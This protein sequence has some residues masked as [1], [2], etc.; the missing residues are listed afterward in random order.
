MVSL[1]ENKELWNN[2]YD[3][4]FSGEEWSTLWG[5]SDMQWYGTILPRIQQFVPSPTVLE[6]A[7]GFGR[8][9]KYLIGLA[10]R[11]IV[12]DLAEKCIDHCKEIFTNEKHI[13]YYV[14]D[15]KSL[16]M[17]EDNTLD[18]V[19]S[20]D[21]LV[22]AEMVVMHIY[23]EQL[24]KKLS[25][26]GVAFIHHS[27]IGEYKKLTGDIVKM[28][29]DHGRAF[30]VTADSVRASVESA[31]LACISQETLNWG[32]E[33]MTDCI[34]VFTS[35]GSVYER[36][37]RTIANNRFMLE[38][39]QFNEIASIYGAGSFHTSAIKI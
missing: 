25:D 28:G 14:N 26:N 5:G 1:E 38:A 22:H 36:P 31:G 18:F 16:D 20:Y 12:I 15:G 33:L 21:S 29:K 32:S 27:N 6:I 39:Q 35:V 19:F 23:F 30:S 9:T 8:W 24:S 4:K 13:K 7:P 17:L 10:E 2:K 11:L 3:W 37:C 34:T